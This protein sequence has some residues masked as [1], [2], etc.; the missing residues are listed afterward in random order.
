MFSFV[1]II[2]QNI[3]EKKCFPAVTASFYCCSPANI[4]CYPL[5]MSL[6]LFDE[7]VPGISFTLHLYF[8]YLLW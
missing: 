1:I 8:N 6:L 3:R 2:T 7:S 4:N 5:K